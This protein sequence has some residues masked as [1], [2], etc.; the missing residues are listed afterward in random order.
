MSVIKKFLKNTYI[1]L[2]LV[3]AIF[4]GVVVYFFL[5]ATVSTDNAYV[6]STKIPV[7]S[8]VSGF[9]KEIFVYDNSQVSKDNKLLKIDDT[10]LVFEYK[11]TLEILAL[12]EKKFVR[13]ERLNAGKFVAT[14]E[15]ESAQTNY[16]LNLIKKKELEHKISNTLI[17]SPINGIVTKQML[18]P[19]QYIIAYKPLFFIVNTDSVWIEANFKETQ[20]KNIAP[21]QQAEVKID[22]YPD[23]VFKGKVDTISPA[24]GSEFSVLP[25]DMSYGN[26]VKIVQRIPVKI[27]LLNANKLLKPGMSATVTIYKK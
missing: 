6:K 5:P 22:A 15:L 14:K 24:T 23:L 2:V 18:E 9:V 17:T 27:S 3:G 26:F 16:S 4:L 13:N 8:E 25:L 7:V 1:K 19:G 11:K 10:N 21:G 12:T 20:I